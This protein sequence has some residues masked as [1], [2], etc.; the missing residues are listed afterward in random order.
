MRSMSIC[1]RKT[2]LWEQQQSKSYLILP[3]VTPLT[4]TSGLSAHMKPW[5]TSSPA[6][7]SKDCAEHLH[8][9][10][11]HPHLLAGEVWRSGSPSPRRACIHLT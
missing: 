10:L 5:G 9:E 11:L 8:I 6:S 7:A 4:H 2:L 3:L 1:N